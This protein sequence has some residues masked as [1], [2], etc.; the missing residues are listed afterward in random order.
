M[1][2][3]A[4]LKTTEHIAQIQQ[5]Q[6]LH[7]VHNKLG[8]IDLKNLDDLLA[9]H[10]KALVCLMHANNEI[11]NLLPIKEVGKLCRQHQ[12]LFF[13]DM[14]QTIG[15][16][17]IYLDELPIDFAVG[18]AHKFYGSKG[19][20]LLYHK[21]NIDSLLLGGHQERNLRAGT[22]NI[23][24]IAAIAE[25]LEMTLKTYPTE[26]QRIEDLKFFCIKLLQEKI[27]EICF[28]GNCQNGGLYNLINCYIPDIETDI[29]VMQ[30]D[31]AG[32]AVSMG[33]AC[34]S[35]TARPSHVV[36]A[37]GLP[38]KS[39]RISLGIPTQKEDIEYMVA[40]MEKLVKNRTKTKV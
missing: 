25:A 32:I 20:G 4:L 16:Y 6:L 9:A 15:K 28:V 2:H 37:L 3:A 30:L 23:A 11:G 8:I 27:P 21:Q 26:K 13:C 34:S 7:V 22:E 36:Q 40:Q 35:G 18:S 5:I 39:I 12:A 38:Q 1:E 31:M 33:S 10:P 14:V 17:P 24:A 29:L 19:C